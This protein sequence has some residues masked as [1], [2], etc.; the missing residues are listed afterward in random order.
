MLESYAAEVVFHAEQ[1]EL[2]QRLRRLRSVADRREAA[3]AVNQVTPVFARAR[4]SLRGRGGVQ[5]WPRPI[6]LHAAL[7]APDA[8]AVC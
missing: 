5:A 6:G 2:H 7:V 8:V 4:R 1:A 3:L